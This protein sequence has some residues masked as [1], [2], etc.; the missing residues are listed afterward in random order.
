MRKFLTNLVL[1]LLLTPNFVIADELK[2]SSK[3][4]KN[5]AFVPVADVNA[6]AL[7]EHTV[8]AS[9]S[10]NEIV[11]DKYLINFESGDLADTELNN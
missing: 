11:P 3:D 4:S 7:D 2:V 9:W 8:K 1:V 10:W 6:V 5:D